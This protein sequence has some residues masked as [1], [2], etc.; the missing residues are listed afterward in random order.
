MTDLTPILN[1]LLKG[2]DARPTA[3]PAITLR[4]LDGFLKEA[5]EIV[6]PS[7]C[8]FLKRLFIRI[9]RMPASLH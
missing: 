8:H 3:D 7:I 6:S 9:S 1:E 4:N 2:Y 5:Y